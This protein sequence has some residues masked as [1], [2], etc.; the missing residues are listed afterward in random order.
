[1]TAFADTTIGSTLRAMHALLPDTLEHRQFD[2]ARSTTGMPRWGVRGYLR[3]RE[4]AIRG[5]PRT[6]GADVAF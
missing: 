5:N 2:V 6:R 4:T 1:M 3:G